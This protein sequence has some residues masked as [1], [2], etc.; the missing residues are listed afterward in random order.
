M[1]AE[2]TRSRPLGRISGQIQKC[3][4]VSLILLGVLYISQLHVRLGLFVMSRQYFGLFLGLALAAIF[5]TIPI[6]RKTQRLGWYDVILSV[7]GLAIGIYYTVIY[8]GFELAPTFTEPE[9]WIP[10]TIAIIVCLEGTRRITGWVMVILVLAFILYLCFGYLIPGILGTRQVPWTMLSTYLFL[11]ANAMFGVPIATVATMVLGFVLFGAVLMASGGGDILTGLAIAGFGR[12]TG[13]PAKVGVVGSSLFGMLSGSVS[14]NVVLIGSVTIPMMKSIGYKPYTAAAIEAVG[15]TGGQLMPPVMGVAA[16]MIAEFLGIPYAKVAIAAFPPA[17]LYYYSL[18][19]QVHFE[20]KKLGLKG[21]PREQIPPL[22]PYLRRMWVVA[23]PLIILIYMLFILNWAPERVALVATLVTLAIAYFRKETRPSLSGLLSA[24]IGA[25]RIMIDV[26][27]ISATAGFIV[28]AVFLSGTAFGLTSLFAEVAELAPLLLLVIALVAMVLGMGMTTVA[29]YVILA[30][31]VVPAAIALGI[32]P[33]AAHLFVLYFAMV[34]FFTPPVCP[35]VFVAAPMAGAPMM[36]T[37]LKA[38]RLGIAGY[39]VPF[40][41]VFSPGLLLQGSLI[42]I[43]LVMVLAFAAIGLIALA[44]EGYLLKPIGGLRR[45]LLILAG[46]ALCVPLSMGGLAVIFYVTGVILA[47]V[48]L[49]PEWRTI[50]KGIFR[51][52]KTDVD[53]AKKF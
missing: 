9:R 30:V 6:S 35:A 43:V 31:L 11:D 25:G 40:L 39:I 2:V 42:E 33:L 21:L 34:S 13:G 19:M 45:T 29:I 18:F 23:I 20:A 16:F 50:A 15:S 5:L 41:F 10:G 17:V 32:P 37:G 26:A 14:A 52:Q 28:G 22:R 46:L 38:A 4:L 24:V 7:L 49:A 36:Q 51:G 8:P 44:A 48:V 3:L 27:V 12:F 1:R 53:L 47:I